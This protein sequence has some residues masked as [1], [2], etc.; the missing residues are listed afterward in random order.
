M[1]QAL[2]VLEEF[3]RRTRSADPEIIG[4]YL[5]GAMEHPDDLVDPT[6]GN[7]EF[8]FDPTYRSDIEVRPRPRRSIWLRLKDL[9]PSWGMT[10]LIG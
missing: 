4:F 3:Q 6:F 8:E 10:E 2:V 9:F 5:A 7:Y 1:K